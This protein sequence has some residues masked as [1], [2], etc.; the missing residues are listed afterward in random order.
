VDIEVKNIGTDMQRRHGIG[1][2]FRDDDALGE[3]QYSLA[4]EDDGRVTGTIAHVDYMTL[5]RSGPRVPVTFLLDGASGSEL[6]LFLSDGKIVDFI[7][8]DARGRIVHG[9]Y[10]P[11]RS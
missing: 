3:V 11:K 1:T 4:L 10:R 2:V 8:A 6:R 5:P 9:R 7:M